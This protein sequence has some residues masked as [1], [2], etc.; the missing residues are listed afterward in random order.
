MLN[1]RV[2]AVFLVSGASSARHLVARDTCLHRLQAKRAEEGDRLLENHKNKDS[3][4]G[5]K[6]VES[7]RTGQIVYK[8]RASP[9]VR[10]IDF[11]IQCTIPKSFIPQVD[12]FGICYALL[13]AASVRYR[14]SLC[15][16]SPPSVSTSPMRTIP[17]S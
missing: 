17:Q 3:L 7:G 14:M 6:S 4:Y 2:F 8:Y 13:V 9:T 11:I 12:I 16:Q 15:L 10:S 1:R 5:K